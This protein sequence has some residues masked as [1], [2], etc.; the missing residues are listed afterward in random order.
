LPLSSFTAKLLRVTFQLTNSNA[1]FVGANGAVLGNTLQIA[2][3]RMSAVIKGAGFPSFPEMTLKIFGMEQAD[4]NALAVQVVSSGK[5]GWLPN[6]VLVEANSGN[7]WAAAFAGNILTAAPDYASMPNVPLVVTSMSKSYDLVNPAT[8]TS[9][10]AS[11]AV[12]D[13]ISV[14]AAKMGINAINNGVTTVTSG[15]T[16]FPQASADQLRKVCFAYDIDPVFSTDGLVVTVT[17]KGQSDATAPFVLS[18]T[19]GLQGYPTPQ[20]NGFLAVRSLYNPAFH[21]KS[22]IVVQGSDVVLD[23]TLKG[24]TTLNSIANGSWIVTAITNTLEASVPDGSWFSDMI[25]YP[26]NAPAVGT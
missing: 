26:P 3:L 10:P 23:Q 21:V 11:A 8:P 4:M 2:G 20:A 1:V 17:P 13:I 6:T 16:Y 14:I 18:P 25:L 12:F 24:S 19:S 15:A 5:T 7:G 9:F 22:P